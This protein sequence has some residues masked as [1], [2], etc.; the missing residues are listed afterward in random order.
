[1]ADN[2]YITYEMQGAYMDASV[3]TNRVKPGSFGYLA[4]FDGR[5]TG[6]LRK[7]LG[8]TYVGNMRNGTTPYGDLR[9]GR[10]RLFRFVHIRYDATTTFDGFVLVLR[11]SELPEGNYD[12]WWYYQKKVNGVAGDWERYRIRQAISLASID[13]V[14]CVSDDNRFYVTIDSVEILTVMVNNVNASPV[15]WTVTGMGAGPYVEPG[16]QVEHLGNDVDTAQKHYLNGMGT[17]QIGWRFASKARGIVGAMSELVTITLDHRAPSRATGAVYVN[18]NSGDDGQFVDGDIV[19]IGSH[20]YEMDTNNSVA[21]NNIRVNIA[22]LNLNVPEQLRRLAAAINANTEGAATAVP[23]QITLALTARIPGADGNTIALQVTEVGTEQ[24]D[25]SVSGNTLSGG[26]AV[27]D[28]PERYCKITIGLPQWS[29]V[30]A[31]YGET[32]AQ[33]AARW[34]TIEI[35]RTI[36]LGQQALFAQMA[37]YL[38][39]EQEISVPATSTDWN[40]VEIQVGKLFDQSLLFQTPYNPTTDVVKAVPAG[41]AIVRYENITFV[42]QPAS[43]NDGLNISHSSLRHD[44]GEYFSTYNERRGLPIEGPPIRMVNVADAM[45]VICSNCLLQ[46]SKAAEGYPLIYTRYHLGRGGI[47]PQAAHAVGNILLLL[48]RNGLMMVHGGSMEMAQVASTMRIF[49]ELWADD[50]H[51]LQSAYDSRMDSSYILNPIKCQMLQ[52]NH[53]TQSVCMIENAPFAAIAEAHIAG[54]DGVVTSTLYALSNTHLRLYT[55]KTVEDDYTSMAGVND[56][57]DMRVVSVSES[58]GFIRVYGETSRPLTDHAFQL[59]G[60]H[61][62]LHLPTQSLPVRITGVQFDSITVE[63]LFGISI[64][65]STIAADTVVTLAP[66]VCKIRMPAI[67]YIP[68]G[69]ERRSYS[70]LPE[71]SRVVMTSASV[72][73]SYLEGHEPAADAVPWRAGAYRNSSSTL[74][75]SQ[76]SIVLSKNPAE[77]VGALRIDGIDIEPYLEHISTEVRFELTVAD[78]GV[79][80]PMSRKVTT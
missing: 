69:I 52:I 67:R 47:T 35:F 17:F 25:L 40:N 7:F 77:A 42:T 12:V 37:G 75:D 18:T 11:D 10:V 33:M 22:G 68:A 44:S 65:W 70:Q 28:V 9:N 31:Q 58:T 57:L 46:T 63:P 4:G 64:P 53:T 23:G 1:M 51:Y 80:L 32:Y 61:A 39:K 43:E 34:D 29:S 30:S 5:F 50:L 15:T 24:N 55:L 2:T 49:S 59:V 79:I 3:P 21:G 27:V 6:G 74:S 73:L 26:G 76:T 60:M 16:G 66:V 38:Y 19:R 14:D 48:T 72:K 13:K 56:T 62:Y 54:S 71:M 36:D 20:R 41:R 45:V 8:M 78:I